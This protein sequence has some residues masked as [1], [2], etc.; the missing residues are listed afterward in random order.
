MKTPKKATVTKK[1]SPSDR[2]QDA[3]NAI[4]WT[5]FIKASGLPYDELSEYWL[6]L[7]TQ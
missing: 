1:V 5:S 6:E 7:I 4:R 2:L 3:L